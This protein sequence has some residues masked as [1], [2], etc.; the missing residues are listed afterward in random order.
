MKSLQKAL[1]LALTLSEAFCVVSQK[2]NP[3]TN[4]YQLTS[5]KDNFSILLP[6]K[7]EIK[8]QRD[9]TLYGMSEYRFYVSSNKTDSYVVLL[10]VEIFPEELKGRIPF[11]NKDA[12]IQQIFN[13]AVNGTLAEAKKQGSTAQIRSSIDRLHG[14]NPARDVYIVSRNKRGQLQ[15]SS[16]RLIFT[17]EKL[18]MI[19]IVGFNEKILI[20]GSFY[21]DSFRILDD[22][23]PA[24]PSGGQI[25]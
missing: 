4:P 15:F 13:N 19:M 22:T 9:K 17:N 8:T 10:G 1:L 23:E 24:L 14:R 3:Y 18:Y 16:I 2:R 11:L 25:I 12:L 20:K 7:P 21:T 5:K 6:E